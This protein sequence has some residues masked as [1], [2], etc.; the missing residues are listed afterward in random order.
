MIKQ[1]THLFSQAPKV[2]TQIPRAIPAVHSPPP[3]RPGGSVDSPP[4]AL[5]CASC[6]FIDRQQLQRQQGVHVHASVARLRYRSVRLHRGDE[7]TRIR[8]WPAAAAARP[9]R[10]SGGKCYRTWHAAVASLPIAARP[11][12]SGAH[13]HAS[14]RPAAG[15]A[16]SYSTSRQRQ[17]AAPRGSGSSL[18]AAAAARRPV[19]RDTHMSDHA[20]IIDDPHVSDE[21]LMTHRQREVLP[22]RGTWEWYGP[23]P[24]LRPCAQ[25]RSSAPGCTATRCQQGSAMCL[26][27]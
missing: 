24:Q 20:L 7:R 2:P 4:R 9:G 22:A 23:A 21:S 17:L 27:R 15:S 26:G 13:A 1:L 5:L 16:R 8:L 12:C 10:G 6:S 3:P 14:V 25:A 18:N 19:T 11:C